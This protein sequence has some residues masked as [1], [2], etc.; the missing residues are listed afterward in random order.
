MAKKNPHLGST[1]ESLL[2]EDGTYE[3]AKILIAVKLYEMGRLSTGAAAKLAGVP[4][5][6]FLTKLADYG[7]DTFDLSDEELRRD[8][9]HARRHL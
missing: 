7:V 3:D 6:L 9:T 8:M 2:R 5:P 4:K 1:L